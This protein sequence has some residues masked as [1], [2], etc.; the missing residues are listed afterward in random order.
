[1]DYNRKFV[2]Q[3]REREAAA[4]VWIVRGRK[5]QGGLHRRTKGKSLNGQ[6]AGLGRPPAPATQAKLAG[7]RAEADLHNLAQLC[8]PRSSECPSYKS[9]S[10]RNNSNNS[11]TNLNQDRNFDKLRPAQRRGRLN[12][13]Q[14]SSPEA[15]T[16]ARKAQRS[17]QAQ[18]CR[19]R[20]RPIS[21][22]ASANN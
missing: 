8:A 7:R 6:Q 19:R 15:K 5:M 22:S 14:N 4:S 13:S 16:L 9:K 10:E 11:S 2:T 21:P 20:R 18:L 1:L 3:A 12:V 17:S